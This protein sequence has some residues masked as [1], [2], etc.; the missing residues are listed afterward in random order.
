MGL[1]LC[2][3]VASTTPRATAKRRAP[4]IS[5]CRSKLECYTTF[6]GRDN[7]RALPSATTPGRDPIPIRLRW[8]ALPVATARRGPGALTGGGPI[9]DRFVERNF[10]SPSRKRIAQTK[11]D[12][13]AGQTKLPV[14]DDQEFIP[15]PLY[16]GERGRVGPASAGRAGAVMESRRSSCGGVGLACGAAPAG[17]LKCGHR[18]GG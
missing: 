18:R 7:T 2:F 14:D 16:A 6:A 17:R 3:P 13:R 1:P 15:R 8:R 10:A 11:A 5:A 4:S 9:G 12:G